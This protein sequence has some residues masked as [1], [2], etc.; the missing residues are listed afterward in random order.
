[1]GETIPTETKEINKMGFSVKQI[2]AIL[3]DAGLPTDKL[4]ETT[5]ELCSRHAT[6]LEAIKEERDNFKISAE[7]LAK[8]KAELDALKSN[9]S[10]SYKVKYETTKSEY[11][12]YKKQIEQGEIK[13]KKQVAY[14]NLLNELKISPKITDRVVELADLNKIE[15]DDKGGIKNAEDL[16]KNLS[17]EWKDFI[18]TTSEKGADV[19][20]PLTKS[21]EK[22]DLEKLPIEEYIKARKAQQE[23]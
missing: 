15:F 1:M 14:K 11:D 20:T 8:T 5:T 23:K 12:N 3:S 17:E 21:Q 10:D 7:E 4:E 22:Q 16:S 2:K 13:S 9:S 18:V 6:D 19:S